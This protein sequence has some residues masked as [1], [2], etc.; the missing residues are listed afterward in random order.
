MSRTL[1]ISNQLVYL[2]LILSFYY[3]KV[4]LP[5]NQVQLDSAQIADRISKHR[6][7]YSDSNTL[8]IVLEES[9]GNTGIE[10]LLE[11]FALKVKNFMKL[12][13]VVFVGKKNYNQSE[14]EYALFIVK[15]SQAEIKISE[16]SLNRVTVYYSSQQDLMQKVTTEA[17]AYFLWISDKSHVSLAK[18]YQKVYYK[19]HFLTKD[20][21]SR[22]LNKRAVKK[23]RSGSDIVG[24]LNGAIKKVVG[25]EAEITH[26]MNYNVKNTFGPYVNSMTPNQAVLS[27]HFQ[28]ILER[29]DEEQ[30]ES[31]P[32][33]A[34]NVL[35]DISDASV[36]DTSRQRYLVY[37][38]C[39]YLKTSV[40]SLEDDL[41]RSTQY[42]LVRNFGLDNMSDE[43]RKIFG[44]EDY[45]SVLLL[46]NRFRERRILKTSLVFLRSLYYVNENTRFAIKKAHLQ[47]IQEA[48]ED[49]P[50]TLNHRDYWTLLSLSNYNEYNYFEST[51]MYEQY[52]WGLFTLI[53]LSCI[54]P[55]FKLLKDE[56]VSMIMTRKH[57]SS[58]VSDVSLLSMLSFI[59]ESNIVDCYVDND[60]VNAD[61]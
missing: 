43:F 1:A 59:F 37:R 55:M 15:G 53:F 28:A 4:H 29:Y 52:V 36:T 50:T 51:Y 61:N 40:D 16:E 18:G 25:Q 54:S 24:R 57:R 10:N 35:L 21:D 60:D 46:A 32:T 2:T 41:L 39:L 47:T 38:N 5:L 31:V 22:D 23:L 42:L 27:N 9:E 20:Q 17:F 56:I 13:E 33:H 30:V 8:A 7:L 19:M 44:R 26:L 49:Y 58:A 34:L 12:G 3:V 6:S 11:S 45:S 14:F 48:L